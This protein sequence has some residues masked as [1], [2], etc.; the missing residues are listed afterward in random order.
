MVQQERGVGLLCGILMALLCG[1]VVWNFVGDCCGGFYGGLLCGIVTGGRRTRGGFFFFKSSPMLEQ[2]SVLMLL[3]CFA[4]RL[5]CFRTICSPL[6]CL[7]PCFG[8]EFYGILLLHITL[9]AGNQ[10]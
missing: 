9:I 6:I 5:L 10:Y 7:Q 8:G 1:I 2:I 3:A 4:K